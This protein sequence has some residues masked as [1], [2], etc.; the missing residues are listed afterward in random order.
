[1][2]LSRDKH[3]SLNPMYLKMCANGWSLF[4][5]L[6]VLVYHFQHV[7][8]LQHRPFMMMSSNGNI[9]HITGPLC[10]EFTCHRGIPC[11]KAS[12]AELWCFLWSAPWINGWVNNCEAG[13]LRCYG[14]YYD[15]IVMLGGMFNVT[16]GY[17]SCILYQEY[18][19]CHIQQGLLDTISYLSHMHPCL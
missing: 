17:L 16:D 18:P 11:T 2:D 1:M 19:Q 8:F 14:S 6:N 13:D 4:S 9:F 5:G 15:V 3:F 7:R 10:G 12:D